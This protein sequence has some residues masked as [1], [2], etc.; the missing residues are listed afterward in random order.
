MVELLK[1]RS[2]PLG[3][4]LTGTAALSSFG[5]EH[6]GV[7]EPP[8]CICPLARALPLNR[9]CPPSSTR[10]PSV[11]NSSLTHCYC[12]CSTGFPAAVEEG[13]VAGGGA[14]LLH[15]SKTLDAVASKL[16]NFDQK[17]GVQII[18]NALRVP[19]RTIASNAGVEGA[20]IVGKVLEMDDHDQGYDAANG[21]FVNMV[22]A[23]IIDP[24]KVRQRC[25]S[26]PPC[27]PRLTHT[28]RFL[29]ALPWVSPDAQSSQ[30]R[31]LCWTGAALC[32]IAA[33]H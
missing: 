33:A 15:A 24:L 25:T 21:V 13:I 9:S 23:G 22:K 3:P 26:L 27:F 20:V 30:G 19:M 29:P 14:A 18:A 12:C 16:D 6:P 17:I 4:G 28:L 32:P 7:C 11:V 5:S 8:L 1:C 31:A 2:E 10:A